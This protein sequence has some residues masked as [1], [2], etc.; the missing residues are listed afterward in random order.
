MIGDSMTDVEA[1]LAVGATTFLISPRLSH[2]SDRSAHFVVRDIGEAI[3]Q[4]LKF[5]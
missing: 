5:V 3:E 4:I 1:G 2:T